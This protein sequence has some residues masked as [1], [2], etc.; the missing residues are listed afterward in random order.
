MTPPCSLERDITDDG[1]GSIRACLC[2]T[3]LCNHV[4][5]DSKELPH[6]AL[7][8]ENEIFDFLP[9]V[10]TATATTTTTTTT[11][12]ATRRPFTAR[13]STG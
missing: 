8:L 12:A 4:P 13:P 5:A 1:S 10:K 3:D 7:Q 11:T 2:T 6:G 9:E